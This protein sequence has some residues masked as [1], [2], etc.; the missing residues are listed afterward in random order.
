MMQ[1]RMEAAR[2]ESRAEAREEWREELEE[3]VA[4]ER[5]RVARVC[6]EFARERSK[7]F[8]DGGEAGA[9]NCCS[10]AAS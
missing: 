5:A 7:Y 9:G 8:A 6:E 4:E 2:R 3:R 10:G 1:M